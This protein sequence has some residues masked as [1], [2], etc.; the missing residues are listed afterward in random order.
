MVI[1]LDHDGTYTADPQLWGEFIASCR[2]RG[3]RVI[4][5]TARSAVDRAHV[6]VPKG[7]P[8][9]FTDRSPKEWYMQK[10]GVKV[11]VWIDDNPSSIGGSC[12]F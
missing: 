9:Y 6:V 3:H 5:V 4:C 7:V 11:D 10:Q 1:A 8:V 12:S 2:T